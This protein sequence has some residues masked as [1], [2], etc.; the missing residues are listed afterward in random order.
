MPSIGAI[1]NVYNECNAIGGW[2]ENVAT[3]ADDVVVY[4]C[5]PGGKYSDDGTIEIIEK[6]GARLVFGQIDEGFGVVRSKMI[7][8]TQAEFTMIMDADE[9]FYPFAPRLMCSGEEAY[10]EVRW[11]ALTVTVEEPFD[12]LS[13][14]RGMMTPD[15]DAVCA[16]RRHWFNFHWNLPCQNWF[17]IQDWQ[18]RIVRNCEHITYQADIRMHEKIIDLRTGDTPRF[19]RPT[20]QSGPFYEHYHCWFKGLEP[21]Q[22]EHDI[23]IYDALNDGR[24]VPA[25]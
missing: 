20:V 24:A 1:A 14:L 6:W 9:R 23:R 7:T 17:A 16:I 8:M 15:V 25:E 12:Q 3:W 10:P 5:G 22:R 18:L 11:P 21:S 2:L 19:S 4:H 13:I